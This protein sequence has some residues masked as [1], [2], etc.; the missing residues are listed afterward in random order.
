MFLNL[1]KYSADEVGQNA[2]AINTKKRNNQLRIAISAGLDIIKSAIG[3]GI[4]GSAFNSGG[5]S[6]NKIALVEK[7]KFLVISNKIIEQSLEK[8]DV[9]SAETLIG[10]F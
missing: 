2:K 3:A 1:L 8:P 7:T 6:Q 4:N 9:I 10:V 5:V